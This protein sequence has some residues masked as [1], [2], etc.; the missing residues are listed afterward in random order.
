MLTDDKLT[1]FL[2]LYM[3]MGLQLLFNITLFLCTAYQIR[4]LQQETKQMTKGGD[5]R[6]FNK[7]D[8][9]KDR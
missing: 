2:Y 7:M 4:K 1:N 5:S 3:I 6:K 8:A 9:D